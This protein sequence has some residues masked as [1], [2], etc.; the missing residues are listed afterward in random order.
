M[1]KV[2]RTSHPHKSRAPL[3]RK[4]AAVAALLG[5]TFVGFAL[6]QARSLASQPNVVTAR[7][8]LLINHRTITPAGAQTMLGSLPINAV[9]SPDGTHLLVANSGAASPE[10]LQVVETATHRVVQS[11]PYDA[12]DGVVFGLAYSPDGTR[13]F[14][15][16]GGFNTIHTYDVRADGTLAPSGDV[17]LGNANTSIFP[18]GMAVTP[19]GTALAVVNNE[20]NDVAVIDIS[21]DATNN[22]VVA[23]VP[24]GAYPYTVAFAPDGKRA[25]VSNEQDAT[26]SVIDAAKVRA[27]FT[28]AITGGTLPANGLTVKATVA[29]IHTGQ[30]PTSFAFGSGGLLYVA[31]ANSD[32]I[33][34][35][36]RATNAVVRTISTQ[37]YAGAPLSAS[38]VGLAIDPARNRLYAVEPG[39]DDVVVIN[40]STGRVAGRIPTA[41]YPT[42][43]VLSKNR[44]TL[45]ITNGKGYGAGPNDVA[46]LFPDPA[47]RTGPYASDGYC[48]CAQSQ[49]SGSMIVGMLSIVGVPNAG[50]LSVYTGQVIRNNHIDDPALLQ[51]GAGNPIPVPGGKSPFTH[52]I[53]IDK[54][55]R[56]YDQVFGDEPVGNRDPRL[57]LFGRAVTPN[58]HSLGERFGLFD[59]FFAD[60]EVSADGHDWIN[61][62]NAS[63]YNEMMWVQDYSQGVGRNRG[64]D[65]EGQSLVNNNAG[66]YLWDTAA[67]AHITFRDYGNFYQFASATY[68]KAHIRPIPASA[69]GTACPGPIAHSYTAKGVVIPPG[70]ALCFPPEQVNPV[71]EPNLVGHFDPRFRTFDGNFRESDRTAEWLREFKAYVADGK[72]PQ[73]ELL[74]LPNDHTQGTTPGVLTPQAHAAEN[75][76]AV[77]QVVDAVSHS[78][79]WRNTLIVITED[80]AQNGPDHVDAHRTTSL[81]ISAYNSYARPTVDSTQYD[82]AAMVRTIELVLGLRPMSQ[83]DALATPMWRIFK[84]APNLTP[85]TARPET[86]LPNQLNPKTAFG[87]AASAAMN[88]A[89]E[90]RAPAD[91]VNHILWHSVKGANTQYP[92]THYLIGGSDGD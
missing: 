69:P 16:A 81:V 26:V 48:N 41:W 18:L 32:S 21:G 58:L 57:T 82:T 22:Q 88:F 68:L 23:T 56:T 27:A 31:N 17:A 51:R 50:Q 87:A 73:L 65:F 8:A 54:E 92:V 14:A 47:R 7:Q 33:S 37:P 80:D 3:S 2:H 90:D 15:S 74:R 63:D 60:A 4:R 29:T 43:V 30:H 64:Y 78:P 36:N 71:T 62:A 85:Y 44:N 6:P 49:Y 83:F 59:N 89:Q 11:L 13:A 24:V 39:E 40:T 20:A 76:L 10:S 70:V 79:Y 72:L 52:V 77:G 75:D 66:G 53:Y 61:G 91:A 12:P 42:A 45:F 55:N 25:Y 1:A 84:S 35:I 38:P 5:I 67:A 86:V 46:G 9:L 28:N 34:V 19:D